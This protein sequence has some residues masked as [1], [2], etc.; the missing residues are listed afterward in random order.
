[1]RVRGKQEKSKDYFD[2]VK[3]VKDLEVK[4]GDWELV[5]KPMRINKG[6][7]KFSQPVKVEKISRRAVCLQGKGWWNKNAVV[8]IT[9]DQADIIKKKLEDV[10]LHDN[11]ECDFWDVVYDK[12][13]HNRDFGSPL[14]ECSIVQRNVVD[15]F[16]EKNVNRTCRVRN[17]P[18]RFKDFVRY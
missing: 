17:A 12:E 14:P 4:P 15:S 3:S 18:V 9:C 2:R 11:F 8:K 7:S 5:K 16:V 6:D 13:T 1:M 10:P